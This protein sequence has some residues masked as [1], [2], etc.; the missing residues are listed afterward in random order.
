VTTT[1]SQ[2]LIEWLVGENTG[3]SSK[4]MAAVLSGLPLSEG[5]SSHPYDPSDFRRCVGLLNAVPSLR[6]KL[7]AMAA[8]SPEWA[9]LVK[10]WDELESLLAKELA[11]K[12]GAAPLL[13]KRMSQL[14]NGCKPEKV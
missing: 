13:H 14:F 3:Q 8:V 10:E 7:P 1:E 6:L 2:Q 11:L 12:T 9:A 5:R 4:T